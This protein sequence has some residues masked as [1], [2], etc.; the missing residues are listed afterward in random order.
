MSAAVADYAPQS[1]AKEKLKKKTYRHET[2]LKLSLTP[3]ILQSLG[4]TKRNN[5][6]L[7]GFALETQNELRNAR[8]KLKKKHLD[9]IVLNSLK[10]EGAGFGTDTNVV[11]LI[12]RNGK[13]QK[14]GKRPKFDVAQEILNRIK[15]FW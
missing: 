13:T 7:A 4:A 12:D 5:Q 10:D 8:E 9:L 15:K 3:D 2:I 1:P 11:T 14:L 6:V